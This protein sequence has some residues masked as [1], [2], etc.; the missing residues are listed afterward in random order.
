MLERLTRPLPDGPL[1]VT[2][3]NVVL[4]TRIGESNPMKRDYG[5]C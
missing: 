4:F 5:G 3:V 2:D 1:V